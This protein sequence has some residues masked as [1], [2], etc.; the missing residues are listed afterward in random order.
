MG[1]RG[2]LEDL[3]LLDMLQIIAFSKKSGCLSVAGPPGR[4]GVVLRQGRVLFSYSWSTLGRL[5]ELSRGGSPLPNKDVRE[6]IE[7][8]L[9]DLAGL[10][11]GNFQFELT[12]SVTE[13]E[14]VELEPYLLSEGLDPQEL[15]LDLAVEMD[16]DRKETSSLLELAFESPP[17]EE[18]GVR[19]HDSPRQASCATPNPTGFSVVLVDDE[20]PVTEIVGT[21]LQRRGHRVFTASDPTAGRN[22]IRR[23]VENGEKVL[24]AVD[25]KMPTTSGRS[26]YGGFE[27]VRKLKKVKPIVPVLLMVESL[28]DKAKTRA[29][30]LGIRRVVH[31]PTLT[32]IDSE[33]YRK[34]L[35]EFAGTLHEQLKRLVTDGERVDAGGS[36]EPERNGNGS[37]RASFLAAMTRQLADPGG[38]EDVSRLLL[39]VAQEFLERGIL[40]VVSGEAAR[41]LAGYGLD[42]DLETSSR[43]AKRL[44]IDVGRC[45][46]VEEVVRTGSTYRIQG[47]S[48]P[49][50]EAL[51]A[52]AGRG[53]SS[54]A[55]LIPLLHQ[56][57]TLI[58]LFGD[59]PVSG[60]PLGDLSGL[61]QFVSQAGIALEHK[62]RQHKLSTTKA[63][64]G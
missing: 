52:Q 32:K 28:S 35:C 62:L 55:V 41:G 34:D 5:R 20:R 51:L 44:V 22:I 36:E 60:S 59:N 11:E 37:N 10:R 21:E 30:E 45:E 43:V 2:Q 8:S 40:F 25:L 33:L 57:A 61:E 17:P 4:G 13:L 29:K 15:L 50:S 9:R 12:D 1:L 6:F 56:R 3:P 24:A 42:E 18:P 26:F 46:P 64:A 58:I 16:N 49:L 48:P 54:E 47:G 63:L 39:V 27:L 7:M 19:E 53:L 31:K 14:G 38:T 23:R